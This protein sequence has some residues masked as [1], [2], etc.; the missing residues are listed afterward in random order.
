MNGAYLT[1]GSCPKRNLVGIA[2]IS[3]TGG[4]GCMNVKEVKEDH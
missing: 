1:L 4:I 3:M 2:R